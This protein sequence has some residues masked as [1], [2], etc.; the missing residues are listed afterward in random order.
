MIHADLGCANILNAVHGQANSDDRPADIAS[1]ASVLS[2]GG[3]SSTAKPAD[4]SGFIASRVG[5]SGSSPSPGYVV[6]TASMSTPGTNSSGEPPYKPHGG[7]GEE[8]QHCENA[9]NQDDEDI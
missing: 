1:I 6:D 8:D 7:Y 3:E 2:S 4:G 5:P 9:D